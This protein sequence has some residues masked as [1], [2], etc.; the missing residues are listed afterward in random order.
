MNARR[1][2]PTVSPDPF[3]DLDHAF[4]PPSALPPIPERTFYIYDLQPIDDGWDLL[5]SVAT[6]LYRLTTE[7]AEY[8][9]S[10]MDGYIS[11]VF[12]VDWQRARQEA[13]RAGWE[14]DFAEV[15]RVVFLPDP[16]LGEFAYGF[17]FKQRNNGTTFVASPK[18]LPWL[19]TSDL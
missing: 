15:P 17:A 3:A 11:D 18:R 10:G 2:P 6:V 13:R 12:W 16:D 19:E 1:I 5:P 9:M 4:G 7:E 8:P 14:G